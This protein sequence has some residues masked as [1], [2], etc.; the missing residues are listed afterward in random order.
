MVLLTRETRNLKPETVFT[1]VPQ[2]QNLSNGPCRMRV[3]TTPFMGSSRGGQ[4]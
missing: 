3:Q 1:P 4:E 2:P